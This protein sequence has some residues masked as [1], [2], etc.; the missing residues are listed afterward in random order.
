MCVASV[1][2]MTQAMKAKKA[3]LNAYIDASVIKLDADLSK[4]GCSYGVKF[5]CV[6]LYAAENT[7]LKNRIQYNQIINL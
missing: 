3:L 5:D 1:K 4:K 2:S 6:N 7:L